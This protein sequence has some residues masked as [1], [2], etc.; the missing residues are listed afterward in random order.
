MIFDIILI[1]TL[2]ICFITDLR[3]QRIYNKV[4]FPALC[5]GVV[6]RIS[7]YGMDGLKYCIGG[8]GAGL[9]ILLIPYLLGGIGAGDVKLLALIGALKGSM[10]VYNTALYMAVIGGVMALVVILAQ[11][12]TRRFFKGFF[13]WLI[14]IFYGIRYKLELPTSAFLKKFPYGLAIVGGAVICLIF[15]GAWIV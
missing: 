15:R 4:I 2:V 6:L 14:S 9:V 11:G 7:L 3:Q 5:A 10:F 13:S 12:E 1:V 8:F